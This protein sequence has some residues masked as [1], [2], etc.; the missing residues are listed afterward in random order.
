MSFSIEDSNIQV[1]WES[2]EEAA[3]AG[4]MRSLI[5]NYVL[6]VS[7]GYTKTIS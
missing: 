1:I 6:G 5:N 2:H 3:M 4:T 7:E